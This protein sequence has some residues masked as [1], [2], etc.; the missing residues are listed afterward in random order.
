[1]VIDSSTTRNGLATTGMS[2]SL[3][4]RIVTIVSEEGGQSVDELKPLY[5]AIDPDALESLFAPRGDGSSRPDGKIS[6][7]YA[8]YWV[9]VSSDG[10]V[11]VEAEDR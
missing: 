7:Q 1:M 4:E 8:G 10:A 2:G 11:E 5:N 3:T 6:F 9:T